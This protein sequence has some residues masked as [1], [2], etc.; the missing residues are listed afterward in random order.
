MQLGSMYQ[1]N[2]I[3]TGLEETTLQVLEQGQDEITHT[4]KADLTVVFVEYNFSCFLLKD[5]PKRP[6]SK[7]STS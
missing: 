1:L 5:E 3:M 7:S 6:A 4:F 2:Q